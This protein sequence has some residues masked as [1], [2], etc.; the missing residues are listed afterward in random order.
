MATSDRLDNPT[1]ASTP[2]GDGPAEIEVEGVEGSTTTPAFGADPTML[3][4]EV[5]D[6]SCASTGIDVDV[7]CLVPRG[8]PGGPDLSIDSPGQG[9]GFGN[10]LG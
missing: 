9:R 5:V 6:D 1:F 4:V 10:N 7:R 8:G 3:G 2:S